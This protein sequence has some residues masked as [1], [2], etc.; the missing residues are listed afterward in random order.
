MQF[1]EF[2][3]INT[4]FDH[5]SFRDLEITLTSPSG[6]VS[7]LAVPLA[8]ERVLLEGLFPLKG[9]FRFGSARH[10]GEN[11]TGT[12]TLRI[13]DRTPGNPG[14]LESWSLTVYGHRSSP[15]PPSIDDVTAAGGSVRVEW[16]APENP[17]AS[18]TTAYDVR[19]IR[20][21]ATDKADA[22]WRVVHDAWTAGPLTA[23]IGGLTTD[24][25]YD[26]QVRAV[27]AAGDGLWSETKTG[28]PGDTT[29]HPAFDEGGTATRTVAENSAAGVDI[30]DP[31][32]ATDPNSDTLTYSLGGPDASLF[33]LDSS[34]GQLSVASG[35]A[36][37]YE[38]PGSYFVTVTAKDPS[39]NADTITVTISL[40]NVEEAGTVVF[41]HTEFRVGAVL[42][43]RVNDPD[44]SVRSVTWQWAKS[45][46]Q[47]DWTT[48]SGV[49]GASYTPVSADVGMHL[50]ATA[51]YSDGEGSGKSAEVVSGAPVADQESTLQLAV[52]PL[53]SG[54]THPWGIAFTPD[55]TMLFT[56]LRGVL[57]SRLPD[58]A[59]QTVTADFSDLYAS[60]ETGLMGIVVDPDFATNRRFYTCQGH[61]GRL[62]EVI[63]WTIDAAY[64][65]A[66]R[67]VDPLVGGIPAGSRHGGCRLRFGP[68]G[69]LWVATGDAKVGTVPQD[70]LSRG[71]KVLRVDASTGAGAPDNPAAPS[72]IYTSGH[73]NMQGLALRPGTSQMWS[74]EHGP[75]VD[76]EINLLTA[77]GN[78]GWDPVPGYYQRVPMTDLAKF[79]DAVE[80]KWSSGDPTIATSGGIFLEGSWW[81]DWEGRL[82]VAS[83]K[84]ESLR[85]FEFTA[86]GDLVSEIVVAE[87]D[88]TYDR[89]RTPMIGPNGAL[90]VAT[91]NGGGRDQIL[92]VA[93]NRP[94]AFP[95]TTDTQSV[96]ENADRSTIAATVT[97]S[98]PNEDPLTYELSGADAASFTIPDA[99]VGALRV[100]G[101]LDHETAGVLR[102]TVTATDP[103]GA[104]DSIDLT[105]L[106]TDVNE[107]PAFPSSDSRM[108][109]VA[110]DASSSQ[111]VGDPVAAEDDDDDPLT[112]TL[113]GTNAASFGIVESSGQLRVGDSLDHEA[114]SRYSVTVSVSD[115]L[116]DNGDPDDVIDDTIRVTI[117]VTDVNEAPEITGRDTVDFAE[118][119]AGTVATY[120]VTDPERGT[121]IWE[122]LE[123]TDRDAFTFSGGVLRFKTPPDFED[124]TDAGGDNEYVVTLRAS[125]GEHMPTFTVT[126]EVE[127]EEE[128]GALA[129]SSEQPQVGALLTTTLADPDG[130]IRSESWSWHRSTNRG[131]WSEISGETS[132]SYSPVTAD[133]NHYLR[134]TVEYSDGE[135]SGKRLRET[136]DQRTQEPPPMNY[137]P[138]FADTSTTRSVAENSRE[139]VAVGDAVTATD[140]N[141]DRL[142]YTL[143]D[144][145]GAL[146]T[147]DGNGRIRVG[148]GAVL[149]HEDPNA[150]FY[151]VT[152]TATDPSTASDSILVDITVTDVN[153]APEAVRDDATTVEDES[154]TIEVLSNDDDPD[155]GDPNDTLTVSLRTRPANGVA[156]VDAA[157]NDITYTPRANY[158]GADS[159]TYRVFDGALYSVDATVAVTVDSVND[160]PAFPAATAQRSVS[161]NAQPGAN[162]GRA[163]SA[164]D[165]DG[166][167][168]TYT[169]TGPGASAFEIG[170]DTGQITVAAGVTLDAD[171]Q[172]TY[173]VA[174]T[175]E[176]PSFAS[177][178]L[179]V[180]ITV[181]TGG[182]GGG[183][184]GGGFGPGPGEIQLVVTAAVVGE[185]APPGQRFGFAFHCTPP[186]GEP[187]NAWTFSVGAGQ[188]QGRFVPGEIPCSLTVTDDGG[189]D[190]VDGHFTD[191]VLGEENLRI[192]V[193][194]TYG[195]VTTAVPLDAE[196]V[197][198]DA[199]VSL[200]IPEG[201]RD[202]PYAVLLET[203]SESCEAALD[204]DGESLACHTVTLFDA[205]G[206]E[207]TG[208]TLLVP[209][210]ITITLDAARVE[211]LGGIDGVRAARERGELRMRQRDDADTPWQELPFTVGETADGGVEVV[212]TVQAFSD[213]SLITST[214]RTQTV[215]PAR[216]LE[217]RCVGR[218]RRGQ[219]PRRPRRHRRPGR[220]DLPVA[221]READLAQP[222][223]R[224]PAHPQR[225]R[226]LHSRRD[227]LDPV[228]R[229]RGVD[230]RRG[231]TRAPGRGAHPSALPLDRGRLAWGPT[232]PPSPRPSVRRSSRRSK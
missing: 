124:P 7:T 1:I 224:R 62:V 206:A 95:A 168:L 66:T 32:A 125:D 167:M 22:N 143:D 132:N 192:V 63:A 120:G 197:V 3:E 222:P 223:P 48:I 11:P 50:R 119:G 23:E 112:Y 184:G 163:I 145:D 214:P 216:G 199:G 202:A 56:Q 111:S 142:T 212:V 134:V 29:T 46:D 213:F 177:A 81:G 230:G 137:P 193:T 158:H 55:G 70:P 141:N 15:D 183:G 185:E 138:E 140:A 149:D 176:D 228:E 106:V 226:H 93:P 101:S 24:I 170:E 196:T 20:S 203:D 94:P 162:V 36:L 57:S 82:A 156:A 173:T 26:V 116:D 47:S 133:L 115:R 79:P 33:S 166:D 123:G 71:G 104:S 25:E 180:T 210:T 194:F 52:N 103:H 43:M 27:N 54:L 68:Q 200:T 65:T 2:V 77:G 201:S 195:I 34:D 16:A 76:D 69:Y 130:S 181:T 225:V 9:S 157:T 31:V 13:T 122:A 67:V 159:F 6:A 215:A 42:R 152:V 171:L 211:E 92:I 121:V 78:Y 114:K 205:E 64:T 37:D 19:S 131:S 74:V 151:S 84:D 28:K 100:A 189:A 40:T 109:R 45:A 38:K 39:S 221:R 148:E 75:A 144:N 191:L 129:L 153:E 73:R 72:P 105:I 107:A 17:G 169:L 217:R 150:N 89:L 182:G 4:T 18:P 61:T 41:S 49:T 155:A 220:R 190:A 219:H 87:L 164:T 160:P 179:D 102:V 174:V 154:V 209:A 117:V 21:D 232:G 12:W 198:E 227:V 118:H 147:I 86:N 218:R 80:A 85:L 136:S 90:Y 60:A 126:V 83:L 30:G 14:T 10:L 59:V 96:P 44:G 175:A 58:G 110:E 8:P 231:A 51:T 135:G 172:D 97:A 161:Q 178:S 165:V 207:E 91:S 88:G 187:A 204:L 146:F 98:D 229:R 5:P 108:R 208:V 99:N 188:A 186:E 113:G 127:N 139:G 128:T 53:V 35:A